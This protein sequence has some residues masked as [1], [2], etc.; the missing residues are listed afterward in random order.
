[1]SEAER[2]ELGGYV[3]N[4]PDGAVE[5]VC[6]GSDDALATLE[7]RL[8]RGPP[9]ARVESV[10]ALQVSLERDVPRSFEIR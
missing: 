9:A 6:R 1:M 7:Q 10:E 3:R 2:L 8:R 4:L 5:V